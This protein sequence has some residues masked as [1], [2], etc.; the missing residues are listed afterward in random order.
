[1][2]NNKF[3]VVS[4]LLLLTTYANGKDLKKIVLPRVLSS[5]NVVLGETVESALKIKNK[6]FE[7]LQITNFSK[8]AIESGKDH[9]MALT[10]DFNSDGL[11]DIAMLGISKSE[12]KVFIYVAVSN[13]PK[14]IF[15]IF[16]LDSFSLEDKFLKFS[17]MYLTLAE[18]KKA[19]L[20]KRPVL[21]IE[22]N[23]PGD[24]SVT[25]YY[26]SKK[27]N[28]FELFQSVFD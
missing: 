3:F 1:M 22:T 6:N 15:E 25:P 5:A 27:T 28:D 24:V 11:R 13:E 4:L 21:Q 9:P 14:R 20:K 16:E 8:L 10:A 2:L 26:F 18:F 7:L 17:P 19:S 23:G 12:K